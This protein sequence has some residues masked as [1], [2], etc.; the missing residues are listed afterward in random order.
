MRN[1]ELNGLMLL[2][3]IP[4]I[5]ERRQ[6]S[7]VFTHGTH[8]PTAH[9]RSIDC[10]AVPTSV[11]RVVLKRDDRSI[12]A[13]IFAQCVTEGERRSSVASPTTDWRTVDI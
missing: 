3:A 10:K 6:L 7:A 5:F 2:V 4:S 13:M 9:I 1:D 8:P 11:P 12:D